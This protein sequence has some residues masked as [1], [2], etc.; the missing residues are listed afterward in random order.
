MRRHTGLPILILVFCLTGPLACG[1]KCPE[2]K[3]ALS[4]SELTNDDATRLNEFV[5]RRK[6]LMDQGRTGENST[7]EI[8]RLK[9]SV[10]A[11]ELAIQLQLR[12]IG[13]AES[14]SLYRTNIDEINET[15]CF[16]D[17]IIEG[18]IVKNI[19]KKGD[20]TVSDSTGKKIREKHALFKQLFNK[21]GEFSGYELKQYYQKGIEIKPPAQAEETPDPADEEV[22][23]LSAGEDDDMTDDEE[24][25][26]EDD[27]SAMD[28]F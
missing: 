28:D 2:A 4:E 21:E 20:V 18:K 10:T 1:P 26:E 7:F 27:M 19:V 22:G 12:I 11:Y 8:E 17:E 14:S 15:R 25:E 24:D 16:L 23:D 9:F 13:L 3:S 5:E 6:T